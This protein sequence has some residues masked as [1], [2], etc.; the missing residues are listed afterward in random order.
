MPAFSCNLTSPVANSTVSG[1]INLSVSSSGPIAYVKYVIDGTARYTTY[2]APFRLTVDTNTFSN[3]SHTIKPVAYGAGYRNLDPRTIASSPCLTWV[4]FS[5][6]STQWTTAAKTTQVAASGDPIGYVLNKAG[7]VISGFYQTATGQRPTLVSGNPINGL[8]WAQFST[9]NI[10]LALGAYNT[11]SGDVFIVAKPTLTSDIFF[12]AGGLNSSNFI[13]FATQSNALDTNFA[14]QLGPTSRVAGNT[15]IGTTAFYKPYVFNFRNL[16][17]ISQFY[18]NGNTETMSAQVGVNAGSGW[19]NNVKNQTSISI[20]AVSGG[21]LFAGAPYVGEVIVYSGVLS[22][23]DRRSVEV[24]LAEKW[25]ITLANAVPYESSEGDTITFTTQNASGVTM[26][27]WLSHHYTHINTAALCYQS[28]LSTTNGPPTDLDILNNSVDLLVGPATQLRAIPNNR[29]GIVT[30]NTLSQLVWYQIIDWL[31]Y[32]DDHSYSREDGFYH[33][34]SGYAFNFGSFGAQGVPARWWWDARKVVSGVVSPLYRAVGS[35]PIPSL[36]GNPTYFNTPTGSNQWSATANPVQMGVSS[37][38]YVMWGLPDQFDELNWTLNT[39]AAASWSGILEYPSAVDANNVPTT[40][41]RM[42]LISDTTSGLYADGRMHFNPM[43]TPSWK[44]MVAATGAVDSSAAGMLWDTIFSGAYP[45]YYLRYRTV[46]AGTTPIVGTMHNADFCNQ[47]DSGSGI[48]PAFDYAA[49]ID[50]DGYLN[51]VEYSGHAAIATARFSWHSRMPTGYGN[52][53]LWGNMAKQTFKAWCATWITRGIT[54]DLD[55]YFMDNSHAGQLFARNQTV[56]DTT[57]YGQDYG[58]ML[59]YTWRNLSSTS[60][61]SRFLVPNM[62][63]SPVQSITQ[64]L[65]IAYMEVMLQDSDTWTQF[66]VNANYIANQSTYYSPAP[67]QII[68][69]FSVYWDNVLYTSYPAG[70]G[71]T[72][73]NGNLSDRYRTLMLSYYYMIARPETYFGAFMDN[74]TISNLNPNRWFTSITTDIGQPVSSYQLFASGNDPSQP[75]KTYRIYSRQ[76]TKA[77]VLY[78]PL[79]SDAAIQPDW[80]SPF[81]ATV[82]NAGITGSGLTTHSLG[83]TYYPVSPDGTIGSGITSISLRNAEGAI[84]IAEPANPTI[85]V[86]TTYGTEGSVLI[87]TSP[88]SLPPRFITIRRGLNYGITSQGIDSRYGNRFK[89][90]Q[91]H[92]VATGIYILQPQGY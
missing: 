25:G 53:V 45:G 21:S 44:R 19:F 15:F 52:T 26:P 67:I 71:L 61:G 54:S 72:Y 66:N 17:N 31:K 38:D 43:Q 29:I 47:K 5:D 10:L 82:G 50:G 92:Q 57:T 62:G 64:Q 80:N 28:S 83:G 81:Y 42:P 8:P 7:V 12:G 37:G 78:K 88:K 85:V 23:T 18:V 34:A 84:L 63:T 49:D 89:K 9:N 4:D 56:E 2:D 39:K 13:E 33:A 77:L 11:A 20:G 70:S 14:S 86:G 1:V 59:N 87:L 36:G 68:D 35:N 51:D 74:N 79:S 16:G 30:Y 60:R 65:P 22:S 32:A 3:S 48:I 69:T 91:I 90:S 27:T 73:G 24:Y 41:T 40:W 46:R 55:G 58:A 6:L 76:Y 75:T